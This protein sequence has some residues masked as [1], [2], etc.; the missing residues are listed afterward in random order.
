[1]SVPGGTLTAN[2]Y[3][4][5]ISQDGGKNWH[6]VDT[7]PFEDQTKLKALFPQYNSEL[8]IP[9]KQRPIF[10]KAQ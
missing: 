8:K 1:M 4:L 6:F 5:G 7:A 3:L 10:T 9:E 2:S